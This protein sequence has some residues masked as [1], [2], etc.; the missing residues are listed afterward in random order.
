MSVGAYGVERP[1]TSFRAI[2]RSR[3]SPRRLILPIH[4]I[5][6][7][8]KLLHQLQILA[9]LLCCVMV[10]SAYA[11]PAPPLP[12]VITVQDE[13][14]TIRIRTELIQTGVMVL[15]KQ[16]RFVDTLRQEDFLLRVDGKELPVSF[17]E[18]VASASID[19]PPSPS[20]GQA[21]AAS[22]V[23]AAPSGRGRTIIFFV[24]DMHLGFESHKLAR[25]ILLR[26][27]EREMASNDTVAVISSSG[28][29]GFLQQFTDNKTVLRAAVERLRYNKDTS[30]VDRQYPPMSEYEALLIDRYDSEVT[31]AF[32]GIYLGQN[33]AADKDDAEVQVRS[34][35]RDV[36]QRAAIIARNTYSSLEQIVRKS[37]QLP[38]RKIVF[39]ISDGFFLDTTNT[40]SSNRLNR[41]A[42]AAARAN[43][44]VYSFDAKGLDAELPSGVTGRQ[45]RGK[46]G[47]RWEQQDPMSVVAESTGGR[48]TR[49][50][51]D[52]SGGITKAVAEASSYYLLAWRPDPEKRGPDKL[53]RIEVSVKGRPDLR[54]RVQSGYLDHSAKAASENKKA[55]E[56][57]VT[58]AEAQLQGAFKAI[59]PRRD[60]PTALAV[61][62]INLPTEGAVAAI[63]LSIKSDAIEFRVATDNRAT[64]NIDLVGV[65]FNSQGKREDFFRNRLTVNRNAS[66]PESDAPE[67]ISYNYQVK[68]KP[69]LYQVRVAAR[70][71]KS[72]LA[73]SANE[74][75]EIPDLNKKRL[76][77]SSLLLGEKAAGAGP[78]KQP[79]PTGDLEDSIGVAMSV[80]RRFARTSRLRYVL[81]IY[82]ASLRAGNGLPDLAIRTDV[83]RDKR[84]V[85]KSPESFV[86]VKGQA[87]TSIPYAAEINLGTL[88]TGRYILQVTVVD[89]TTKTTASREVNFEIQ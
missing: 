76:A 20:A 39:F 70:D 61:N 79:A 3:F 57:A 78:E 60:L 5:M 27:V 11:Q 26:F 89:R 21:G 14:E 42:D 77:L 85:I 4:S 82:N 49:N 34:R 73:G 29:V 50:T 30:A 36:L 86:S 53:R 58:T 74:W 62:Y 10:T 35:A 7:T 83:L 69:G 25:D 68:L 64:A 9:A 24:D 1:L 32:V 2:L 16:G 8:L 75:V 55:A 72:G 80:G 54:V 65:I 41:I 59:V 28:K 71:E 12:G 46:S 51:N 43:A 38:G 6:P 18:R 15:D 56:P 47:E 67:D 66:Q 23:N 44:V 13:D 87:A 19:G 63:A 33:L 22:E 81:F 48:F 88:A 31:A 45:Y 52:L 37:A 17:F 40:D 84:S